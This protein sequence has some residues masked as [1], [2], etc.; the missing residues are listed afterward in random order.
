MTPTTLKDLANL[1]T[2]TEILDFDALKVALEKASKAW[3]DHLDALTLYETE[4]QKEVQCRAEM[5]GISKS[6]LEQKFGWPLRG[7]ALLALRQEISRSLQERFHLSPL[8]GTARQT[9][10][11]RFQL[12]P[13]ARFQSGTQPKNP[14]SE[15]QNPK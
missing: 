10:E 5:C 11:T 6:Q 8:T 14:K 2:H 3:N 4:L 9:E 1:V 7:Q 13:W 15:I 12:E